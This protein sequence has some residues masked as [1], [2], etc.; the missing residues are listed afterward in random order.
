MI[1]KEPCVLFYDIE[2][3]LTLAYLWGPG[4][5][6]VG[7]KQLKKGNSRNEIICIGYAFNNGKPAKCI[8]WGWEE[9]STRDVV[10]AFDKIIADNDI[11]LIVGKNSARFDNKMVSAARMLN[12]L[13]GNPVW[14]ASHDDL[15]QQMRKY[16]R[17]P[18]QSLEY[19]ASELGLG[20]KNKMEFNDWVGITEKTDPSLL[21]KMV[22]YCKRDVELTRELWYKLS[23]HFDSKFNMARFNDEQVACKHCGSLDLKKN[24]YSMAQGAKY[25]NY[26]C[27]TC[28]RY[29]GKQ[30]V[31]V[32]TGEPTGRIK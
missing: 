28:Y 8:D 19:I 11:D 2:T 18:S 22:K 4:Q 10:E 23:E 24:G 5:Q 20:S 26:M 17:L 29:A 16:F 31:S 9:Q 25:C 6:Y 13:P 7:H 27:N 30:V 32:R 14:A 1:I 3:S 21:K 15:E 12:G